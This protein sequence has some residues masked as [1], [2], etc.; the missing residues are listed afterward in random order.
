MLLMCALLYPASTI[1]KRQLCA[2]KFKLATDIELLCIKSVHTQ[3]EVSVAINL[4]WSLNGCSVL[5]LFALICAS[6]SLLQDFSDLVAQKA[7]QQK[8]KAAQAK[9]SGKSKKQKSDTF[10][11]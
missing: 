1:P 4:I 6:L 2:L 7:A 10:K 8:R 3:A 5:F 9:E 11:F